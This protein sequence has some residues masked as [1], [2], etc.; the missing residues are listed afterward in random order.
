MD[1]AQ[2]ERDD[3][4]AGVERAPGPQVGKVRDQPTGGGGVVAD[5]DVAG[6]VL[7]QR[8]DRDPGGRTDHRVARDP[9]GRGEHLALG[10]DQASAKVG[11]LLDERAEA[12]A[13][14]VLRHLLD[15][16]GEAMRQHFELD[17]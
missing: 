11:S 10:R 1:E 4:L 16:R 12:G 17:R 3:L 9:P 14:D 15:H 7:A 2:R 6:P 13:A 8:L 5:S